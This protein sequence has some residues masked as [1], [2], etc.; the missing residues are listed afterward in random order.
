MAQVCAAP[1]EGALNDPGTSCG[2]CVG[3]ARTPTPS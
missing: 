2:S 1:A 3:T